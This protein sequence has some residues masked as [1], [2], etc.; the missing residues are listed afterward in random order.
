[1]NNT[2]REILNQKCWNTY[3]EFI[4]DGIKEYSKELSQDIAQGKKHKAQIRSFIEK[5]FEIKKIPAD[6]DHEKQ[7]LSS[8]EVVGIDG[9]IATHKT[10]TGTMAQIGVVAVNYLNEK[11]QH[12]YFISE[13]R[14]KQD[15]EDVAEYL[16]SHE[17]LNKV[18]SGPV[19]RAALQVRERELGLKD[20]FKN[21]YKIYHGPLIPF[22]MLANPGKAEL[23]ILDV[24]LDILDD[25]IAN[26]RC[27]SIISRS[28]NDAYLRVGLS[29]NQGEY[30][31]LKKSVGLEILED[32]S[33]L[34]DKDR[35]R[36]EDFLKVNT[37]INS[38]ATKIKVGLIKL[39]QRPYVFHAHSEIFD[40]AAR[41][42]ARDSMF[43]KEK[44]FPLLIDYA[45]NL[46]S[47]FFKASDFNKIIEYQL[48]KEGEFLSEMSEETLRQK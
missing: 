5:H 48:A 39:A 28:R 3:E 6:L 23:K 30:I 11:I 8:G 2:F 19:L 12:S 22:E 36:E 25:I 37:F 29:L 41:I 18:V 44:G 40:Q 42:I 21:K 16:F 46:C 45:D 20:K 24:T 47:T 38:R 17:P 7:L 43:Q 35:W 33:L 4:S 32:R 26:K 13:A 34:K 1:M 31:Q 15:I 9:T 10:I 27:L 14:Y